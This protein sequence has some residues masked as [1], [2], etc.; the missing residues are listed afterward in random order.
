VSNDIDTVLTLYDAAGDPAYEN[1]DH[2]DAIGANS[3]LAE[4][5]P[6]GDWCLAVRP[7]DVSGTG[8]VLVV[9]AAPGPDVELGGGAFFGGGGFGGPETGGCGDLSVLPVLAEGL[10]SGF[11]PSV[12]DWFV[13]ENGRADFRMSLIE[14]ISVQISAGSDDLDTVLAVYDASGNLMFEND[15]HPDVIGTNS[16]LVERLEAG[17]YCVSV[18]GFAGSGG[19]FAV[20]VA[21]PGEGPDL[22]GPVDGGGMDGNVDPL[23]CSSPTTVDL[24]AGLAPG[25]TAISQPGLVDNSGPADFIL[26]VSEAVDLQ[27]DAAS[28]TI[29]TVMT[30]YDLDGAFLD[31]NDDDYEAGGTNSRIVTTLMPG[32]YCVRV[33]GFGGDTGPFTIAVA[34]PGSAG[35]QDG[36]GAQ[37]F[38][39]R[40]A[41]DLPETF[42][43]LG[44]LAGEALQSRGVSR[45]QVLWASF[46]M[47]ADGPVAVQG[48]SMTSGFSLVLLAEDGTEITAGA[49]RGDIATARIDID[50]PAGRYFV[51]MDNSWDHDDVLHLRQITVQRP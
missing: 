33:R 21:L 17:D 29:D 38:A 16:R 46:V 15:D 40:D 39:D 50:L 32:D 23:V 6:A 5:L 48:V 36:G 47:D 19:D 3:R 51:A 13:E 2:P 49:G 28:S 11:A 30:L 20:S 31:E 27:L 12:W 43:D 4:A 14:G 42:E 7:F 25:F 35:P 9:M 45:D 41:L 26:S 18:R 1:D 37:A 10:A 8:N 24:A 34:A 44:V 22:G